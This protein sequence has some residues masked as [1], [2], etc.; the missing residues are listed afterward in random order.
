MPILIISSVPKTKGDYSSR[1]PKSIAFQMFKIRQLRVRYVQGSIHIFASC[2]IS[3]P[4]ARYYSLMIY[5]PPEVLPRVSSV[6][7]IIILRAD[8]IKLVRRGK[9]LKLMCQFFWSTGRGSS[10]VYD[11][12]NFSTKAQNLTTVTSF[13]LPEFLLTASSH[14]MEL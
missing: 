9:K 11:S 4:V 13:L 6:H 12:P 8:T 2:V 7:N 5:E 1:R 3:R 10:T 14:N